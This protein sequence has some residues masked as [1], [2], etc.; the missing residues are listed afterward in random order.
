MPHRGRDAGD[1]GHTG[2]TAYKQFWPA[3]QACAGPSPRSPPP[4]LRRGFTPP[5]MT[6]AD[7]MFDD[8]LRNRPPP[9]PGPGPSPDKSPEKPLNGPG[10]RAGLSPPSNPLTSLSP[11]FK[12]VSP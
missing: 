6:L 3:F 9:R 10:L 7:Q 8:F 4:E 1:K 12:K 2:G 5:P 11:T